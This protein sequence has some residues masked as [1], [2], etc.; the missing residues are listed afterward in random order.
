[1][2]TNLTTVR[3]VEIN[4]K[5]EEIVNEISIPMSK[6][7]E[8]ESHYMTVGE[9]LASEDSEL[10]KY[11]PS[12]YA[13]GSFALGTAI[14]PINKEEYDVD[15]VCKLNIPIT[16]ITQANLKK[17]VGDRLKK[18]NKYKSM[19]EEK[20]R[21]WTLKYSD[22]SKFHLDILPATPDNSIYFDV[23]TY[24]NYTYGDPI[25][26]TD[27]EK[28][29][30]YKFSSDWLKSNPKGYAQW[31]KERMFI[32]YSERR[33]INCCESVD[34]LPLFRKTTTLQKVIKLLKYHRNLKYIQNEH[35]PISIIITTLAAKA[36][37]GENNIYDAMKNI[38]DTMGKYV[39]MR[40]NKYWVVNPV[41]P[42]E[43]FADK[44]NKEPIKA[45][46]FSEWLTGLKSIFQDLLSESTDFSEI[47]NEAYGIN[48]NIVKTIPKNNVKYTSDPIKNSF[49]NVSHK[50]ELKWPMIKKCSVAM[51]ASFRKA[52]SDQ[53]STYYSNGPA[54]PKGGK[55][56]FNIKITTPIHGS[57]KI[58]LQV[59]NTGS[60]ATIAGDL[61]GKFFEYFYI[62]SD[63]HQEYTKYKG[64]HMIQASIIQNG[65]CIGQSEEF[66]V[67][68]Q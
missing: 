1:M 45:I 17:I 34:D 14:K 37:N 13:Q 46:I 54:L 58:M 55:I 59:V 11:E 63:Y 42:D 29:D 65:V 49:F 62:D 30:F 12:I 41:N 57:Y 8:A 4:K 31:F 47:L 40:D 33:V 2:V 60:E 24:K 7:E 20:K 26:I 16:A 6:Y 38:I 10:A 28:E 56:Q 21:C 61:R 18:N 3:N 27:N 66:I 67:N 22:S 53:T 19:L 52:H 39:E 64:K 36:Y 25:C 68:I 51:H 9:W 32:G 5:L 50:E 48:K 44:W 43:N 15:A 23:Y 35:K